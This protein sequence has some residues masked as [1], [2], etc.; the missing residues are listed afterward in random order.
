MQT[1]SYD[2]GYTN[3]RD[4]LET[5]F[6]YAGSL[7]LERELALVADPSQ[8]EIGDVF[9][10]GGSPG[11]AVLVV[12]VAENAAGERV[13]LLAQSYMPAQD[14]HILKS[15]DRFTPWYTARSDG[16]LETPQWS[17]NHQQL[18]RFSHTTCEQ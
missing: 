17:L 18:K 2:N 12:D 3:F 13:F 11:H 8:L 10:E 1:A 7:S 15:Y 6:T 16:V 4:Y 14:I 5:V 9:I